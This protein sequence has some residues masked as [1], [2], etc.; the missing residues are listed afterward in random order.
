MSATDLRLL[1]YVSS[2]V[3][4]FDT[5]ELDHLLV[6]SRA[7]NAAHGV[8]GMLLYHD[9]NF[10]QALEG[11]PDSID[12]TFERVAADPRHHGIIR[13]VDEPLS[14]RRFA[15]WDMGFHRPSDGAPPEGWSDFLRRAD[16]PRRRG[17]IALSILES[18]RRNVH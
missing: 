18:F 16:E 8:T 2:A 11:A 14:V 15:A 9:G 12:A 10:V 4:G 3:H 17:D 13:M 7:W 1:V 5:E 6:R